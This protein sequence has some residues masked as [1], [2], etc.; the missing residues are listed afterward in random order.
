MARLKGQIKAPRAPLGHVTKYDR[1]LLYGAEAIGEYMGCTG[2]TIHQ[3]IRLHGF[4]AGR[5]PN[6]TWATST[7]LI[8]QWIMARNEFNPQLFSK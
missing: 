5:M 7:A 3:W 4:L 6:G 8:D 1:T 2:H